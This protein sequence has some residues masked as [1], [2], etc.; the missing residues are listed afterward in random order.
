MQDLLRNLSCYPRYF[1]G[2]L[3]NIF[4]SFFSWTKLL[5]QNYLTKI[6]IFGITLSA[7]S[8]LYLTLLGMLGVPLK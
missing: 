3:L 7:F 8:L 4:L 6:L 5:P 1:I 2:F